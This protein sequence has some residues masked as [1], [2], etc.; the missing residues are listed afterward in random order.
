[1]NRPI[2]GVMPLVEAKTDKQW[3]KD[4]YVSAI[5]RAGGLPLVLPLRE[6]AEA[7]DAYVAACDGFLA[8]GGVDIAPAEYGQDALPECGD[9][10]LGLDAMQRAL[11]PRILN[12]DKP[13]LGICRGFQ[14]LNVALGGTLWQDLPSQ[15]PSEAEHDMEPP[16]GRFAHRAIQAADSPLLKMI[17]ERDFGVN[18]CHHQGIRALGRGLVPT[19]CCE[20]GL[21]EAVCMPDKRFVHAVQWHPETLCSVDENAAALFRGLV[22][23]SRRKHI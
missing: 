18:S 6:D 20:D 17:P 9:A 8:T 12:A 3:M 1:M 10:S 7:L 21:I 22:D 2:I 15:R 11:F 23:A 13:L 5:L 16:Y 14:Y 19:A 4:S